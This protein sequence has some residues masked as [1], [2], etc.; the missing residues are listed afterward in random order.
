MVA[1]GHNIRI[2]S[3]ILLLL[4]NMYLTAAAADPIR[5]M[6]IHNEHENQL[7]NEC[8]CRMADD[9]SHFWLIRIT[10]VSRPNFVQMCELP[11]LRD[12]T[13]RTAEAP[14]DTDWIYTFLKFYNLGSDR[15]NEIAKY[16]RPTPLRVFCD[17]NLNA[18]SVL[19]QRFWCYLSAFVSTSTSTSSASSFIP[20]EMYTLLAY[21]LIHTQL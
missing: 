13:I 11:Q 4:K 18:T 5:L 10:V 8:D 12:K 14:Y 2:D 20:T 17:T 6:W 16:Q 9:G 7:E 1:I 15:T 3:I 19:C 21:L